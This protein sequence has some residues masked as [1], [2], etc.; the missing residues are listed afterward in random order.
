MT[1]DRL[2]RPWYIEK[3]TNLLVFNQKVLDSKLKAKDL[4][5]GEDGSLWVI[6][7]QDEL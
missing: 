5:I 2:G 1:V 6:N 7:E 3:A 4:S